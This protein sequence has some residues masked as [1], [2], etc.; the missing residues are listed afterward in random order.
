MQQNS[1]SKSNSKFLSPESNATSCGG[2][3]IL[4]GVFGIM[5]LLSDLIRIDKNITEIPYNIFEI[6]MLFVVGFGLRKKKM[7]GIYG[8]FVLTAI[9]L[10]ETILSYLGGYSPI[11]GVILFF[12]NLALGI[13]F[14]TARKT[15]S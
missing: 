5:F 14:W 15:F 1:Q 7:Y 12:I 10:I 4:F 11:G 6:V 8:F 2:L 13:W 3:L 9:Y